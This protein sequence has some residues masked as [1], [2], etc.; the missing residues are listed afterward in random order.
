[1]KNH[2]TFSVSANVSRNMREKQNKHKSAVIWITGLSGSGKSTIAHKVEEELH[3]LGASTFVFDG[4]NIRQGLSSDLT[5]SDNDRGE[6]IRR[7]GEAAKLMM[8][9]GVI[10]LVAAISPFKKGRDFV[11][12]LISE[13]DFFEIYC[14][15]SLEV[16]ESRDTKGLYKRARSGEI[17]NYTGVDSVYEIP[18]N[19]SL[20]IDTENETVEE[21][22][23]KLLNFLKTRLSIKDNVIIE[24]ND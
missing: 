4:D 22:S 13:R 21:S 12:N 2:N 16:C 23:Y 5:F 6:H 3:K 7:M 24:K 18:N 11:R 8:Q 17:K 20:V 19:P 10:V 1:M 9:A 14:R 15:A